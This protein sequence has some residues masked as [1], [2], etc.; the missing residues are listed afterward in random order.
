MDISYDYYRIFYYVAKYKNIT[1]A[2]NA[3]LY[4]QPNVT[5]AIKNLESELGC[6]LFVRTNR[7]VSLTPEGE[8]LYGHV[9]VAF[10]HIENAQRE[11]TRDR[12]LQSGMIAIGASEVALHCFL[13][14]VLKQFRGLYPGVRVR[15]SNYS[16]PQAV[17]ALKEGLMDLAVV[18]TPVDLPKFTKK[19]MLKHIQET[20]VCGAAYASLSDKPLSLREL[21]KYP[22]ICLGAQTKTYELYRAWFSQNGLALTPDIEAA[23]ADQILPMVRHDLGI[24]FVPEEFLL[25]EPQSSGVYRLRLTQPIPSR[26]VCMVKRM[27]RSLSIAARELEKMI[28]SY[29]SV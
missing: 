24:G 21:T 13:L 6:T 2:A 20:A 11:L 15:V 29:A 23:T 17:E 3:M 5:R 26:S 16:T 14:P 7:G 4:N 28:L 19:T 18:T 8:K 1:Q 12:G 25:E 10:E 9:A 22:L 27:D